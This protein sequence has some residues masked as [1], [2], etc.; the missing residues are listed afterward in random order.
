M[1]TAM[2]LDGAA[3]T[4]TAAVPVPAGLV[5]RPKDQADPDY[6]VD[7]PEAVTLKEAAGILNCGDTTIE[8]MRN[9]ERLKSYYRGRSVRLRR[10]QVEAARAWW[11]VPKGK[12]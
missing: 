11:S 8:N 9:D 3:T 12:V 5:Y 2:V 7:G 1:M 4:L 10:A 6:L